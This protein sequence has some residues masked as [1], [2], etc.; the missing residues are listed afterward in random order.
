MKIAVSA[1]IG[2]ALD[3][4]VAVCEEKPIRHD[5]AARG[6]TADG[7]YWV[8]PGVPAMRIGKEYS[9]S[10]NWAQG[11][12]IIAREFIALNG[13]Q[14]PCASMQIEVADG[15]FLA[16][17]WIEGRGTTPLIAAMRCYVA[18]RLGGEVEIP[19]GLC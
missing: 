5:P 9:P 1:L 7:G 8:W 2:P 17:D 6:R 4:A 19:G 3:W 15:V 14:E 12:P 10:T 16:L 13:G 11:G 18:S